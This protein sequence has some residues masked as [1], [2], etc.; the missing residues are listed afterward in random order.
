MEAVKAK[1]NEKL[2]LALIN[3]E[4][5]WASNVDCM[6]QHPQYGAEYE[7]TGNHFFSFGY[8]RYSAWQ[9]EAEAV[10]EM[11]MKPIA[12][13]ADGVATQYLVLGCEQVY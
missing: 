1:P 12:V 8:A 7:A 6:N 9:C 4:Y 2:A 13:D 5:D 11:E 10:F 3:D